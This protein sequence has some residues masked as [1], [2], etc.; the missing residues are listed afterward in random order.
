MAR[1]PLFWPYRPH[2]LIENAKIH[3]LI[4]LSGTKG[5][6]IPSEKQRERMATSCE[7]P[8]FWR[9]AGHTSVSAVEFV[10]GRFRSQGARAM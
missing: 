5:V 2:Q 4:G 7:K 10:L 3:I 8:F 6:S 1:E 9:K